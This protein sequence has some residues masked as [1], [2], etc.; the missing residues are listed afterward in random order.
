MA[1][2][3][4]AQGIAYPVN[5]SDGSTQ[6]ALLKSWQQTNQNNANQTGF[7]YGSIIY[8][9]G[10]VQPTTL[11]HWNAIEAF[12]N[13]TPSTNGNIGQAIWA[14]VSGVYNLYYLLSSNGGS[15]PL[16]AATVQF[17]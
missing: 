1:N 11:A 16:Q 10:G 2:R 8:A 9:C 6:T 4:N 5:T 13:Y 12:F 3:A 14:A 17:A 15:V 7:L